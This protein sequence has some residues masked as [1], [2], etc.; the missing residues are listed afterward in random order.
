LTPE[1]PGPPAADALGAGARQGAAPIRRAGRQVDRRYQRRTELGQGLASVVWL[2]TDRLL[3]RDVAL[4]EIRLAGLVDADEAAV[5]MRRLAR[6]A[7]ALARIRH[8]G[9]VTTLDVLADAERTV[10]V[11]ELVDA[12][13]LAELVAADGPLAPPTAAALA[14]RLLAALDAAHRHGV[15]HRDVTPDSVLVPANG[16][17]KLSVGLATLLGDTEL[18]SSG[19]ALTDLS[20]AAP[21][22]AGDEP[23]GPA[24]DLWG[25]GATLYL[26]VEGRAPFEEAAT[27]DAVA[28]GEPRPAA[29]AGA[30]GPVIAELL[31]F[32]PDRRPAGAQLRE[33]LER[34]ALGRKAGV[35]DG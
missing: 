21:E 28:A 6:E 27:L 4:R 14:V 26:A 3:R 15:V 24:A 33:Q 20:Y 2:A 17:A 19:L 18:G 23:S 29:S 5:L 12:P 32:A 13:T 22:Q 7:K 35:E 9:L 16:W 34:V 31:A 1:P 30:L 10:V 8:P 11:S 25:L